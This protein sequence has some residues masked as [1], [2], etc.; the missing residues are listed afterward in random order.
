MCGEACAAMGSGVRN[1][2]ATAARRGTRRMVVSV[3]FLCAF[4]SLCQVHSA[5][6]D[7][8]RAGV[9]KSLPLVQRGAESFRERSEGR[10]IS[11]HHQ[12]LVL[13][14]VALARE[15]GFLIDENLARAEVERGH[16]FYARRQARSLAALQEPA[17]AQ[18]DP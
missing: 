10:C 17:S 11:C 1:T 8:V 7:A 5:D 15:R 3:L 12:G 9:M 4:V 2:D 6:R 18:A 13:Q 16:G 14:T